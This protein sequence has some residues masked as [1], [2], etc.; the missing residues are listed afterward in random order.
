[1]WTIIPC[2][3]VIK[4]LIYV[5]LQQYI[6]QLQSNKLLTG[7]DIQSQCYYLISRR[8][9]SFNKYFGI[10]HA[11]YPSEISGLWLILNGYITFL[12]F[13]YILKLILNILLTT[14]RYVG[15]ILKLQMDCH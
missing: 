5:K 8:L 1:M 12:A 9:T 3:K 10:Y 13:S 14:T 11:E 2:F 6:P 15:S 7:P 4:F